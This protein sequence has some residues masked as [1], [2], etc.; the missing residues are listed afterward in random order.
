LRLAAAILLNSDPFDQATRKRD[1][2][3]T[4]NPA[5][6]HNQFQKEIVMANLYSSEPSKNEQI[7]EKTDY[8]LIEAVQERARLLKMGTDE[9]NPAIR[10]GD[11][12]FAQLLKRYNNWI[13]KQV[14]SFTGIDL[15]EAYSNALQGFERAI[16]KF[17]LSRG[18]ALVTFASVAVRRAIQG[19]VISEQKQVEK[20]ALAAEIAT[21]YHEDEFIDPYEQEAHEQSIAALNEE[22]G[23]LEASPQLI[24]Q[25]RNMGM[26]YR[27]IGTFIN[28]S[29]DAVRMIYNRA[30]SLLQKQLQP[31]PATQTAEAENL[32][33]TASEPIPKQ[34]WMGR[35]RSRF[36]ETV[37]FFGT[38]HISSN[39][40]KEAQHDVDS[41]ALYQVSS[42]LVL[43]KTFISKSSPL[44]ISPIP[45]AA[46]PIMA[47]AG[48]P[49]RS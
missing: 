47:L 7:S 5:P 42:D 31:Q 37:R 13:W 33:A 35:L 30:V 14:H 12:A 21:P 46:K 4:E 3:T 41:F 38:D 15:N 29:A 18:Y 20:I 19:V 32:S 9:R 16:A 1:F 34:G 10:H 28:K 11:R 44:Q 23:H 26:K 49:R 2:L 17:D 24:L 25:M 40:P 36:S 27:E 43:Q 8:S 48:L 45:L 39:P 6:H 22:I